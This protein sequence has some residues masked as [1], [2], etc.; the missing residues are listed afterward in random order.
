MSDFKFSHDLFLEKEELDRLKKFLRD[1][2][3]KSD[4]LANSDSFGLIRKENTSI[5]NVF[6]NALV[7]ED[8]TLTIKI[9]EITALDNTGKLIYSPALSA[10]AVPADNQWYWV[11]IAH[12]YT[13]EELGTFTVDSSGNLVCTS[14]DAELRTILR[15]QPNY[16]SRISFTNAT[17]NTLE[18]DVLEVIDDQNAILQGDFTNESDLK[19]A[20]VGTFTPGYVPLTSEKYPFQYDS[21][22]VTL[23]QNSSNFEPVHTAGVEFFIARVK[24][25]G[26]T[27]YIED[28]R[29]EIWK[30][31]SNFFLKYMDRFG[32][33]L[34]GV[35]EITFDDSLSPKESNIV[36]IA[37]GFRSS[38]FSV[39]AKLNTVTLSAGL[40]GKYK[41]IT[42]VVDEAFN[43][44]RL[45]VETGEYFRV[46]SNFT[47]GGSIVLQMEQMDANRF[48]SDTNST[49]LISQQLLLVP[50]VEEIEIF[51]KP[52]PAASN[53][54][55]V[56]KFC[57]PINTDVAKIKL[58]VYA[59]TG[60]LYN[61]GYRYKMVK[62]YG[63]IL[64]LP[65]D[66]VGFYNENQFDPSGDISS[67]PVQT[68]YVSDAN[69]G[70]IP[71][72]LHPDAYFNFKER[73]DLGDLAGVEYIE[74]ANANQVVQLYVGANREYIVFSQTPFTL[75]QDLYINLNKTLD[76]NTT[77]IKGGNHFKLNFASTI[78]C[79][80]FKIYVVED[81]VSPSNFT[82]LAELDQ[83]NFDYIATIQLSG[84]TNGFA[85]NCIYDIDNLMWVVDTAND[86]ATVTDI[87]EI[88]SVLNDDWKEFTITAITQAAG[89]GFD[90][91]VGGTLSSVGAQ[92]CLR[93]K[94]IGKTLIFQL[95]Y[96]FIV[97][98]GGG[99]DAITEF[100]IQLSS[101]FIQSAETN[102]I[103]SGA[104]C[105]LSLSGIVSQASIAA[106][107]GVMKIH[108]N[109]AANFG[110]GTYNFALNGSI[111][112]Q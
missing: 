70:F 98:Q 12:T 112:I 21:C 102:A 108:K 93:Y 32:N 13:T 53:T 37:W 14:N 31:D 60:T 99:P 9:K 96:Y 64:I 84:S 74:L 78:T 95:N 100:A 18:Y 75:S 41:D 4:L 23:V 42:D 103:F 87:S 105:D 66:P 35:E 83:D 56:R 101:V 106:N 62:E 50:D 43:N 109:P 82:S 38:S 55:D 67:S 46:L 17:N 73:I 40:G 10:I 61:I 58:N 52:D 88:N 97:T 22:T 63:P 51:C 2:G 36:N 76:D 104:V 92:S 94:I 85:L 16:A 28:K 110:A 27:L 49:V 1:D 69:N 8:A 71:L 20:V 15:G 3:F 26:V 54:I 68:P 34:I 30:V 33:P 5:S 77:L 11:K 39:N 45:Y 7:E 57:F 86:V 29:N 47:V 65:S 59:A 48:F 90:P 19:I 44:W 111:N 25:N 89:G 81:Y 107:S 72:I 91:A 79:G 24:N 80:A 6:D